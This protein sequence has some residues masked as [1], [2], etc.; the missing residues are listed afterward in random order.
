MWGEGEGSVLVNLLRFIMDGNG[1]PEEILSL[2]Q[3]IYFPDRR[4][5]AFLSSMFDK[6][7]NYEVGDKRGMSSVHLCEDK[8]SVVMAV[9]FRNRIP[10]SVFL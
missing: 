8:W 2:A 1:I 9:S 3:G 4:F 6:N 5:F 7:I 10:V